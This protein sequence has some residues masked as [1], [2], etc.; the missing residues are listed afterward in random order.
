[1]SWYQPKYASSYDALGLRRYNG[2]SSN[3]DKVKGWCFSTR[4][5]SSTIA[6][7][8]GKVEGA[9][10]TLAGSTALAAGMISLLGT[11]TFIF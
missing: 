9:T 1:M 2:G 8:T 11:S 6:L 10:V 7:S 4:L 5:Q 3:A